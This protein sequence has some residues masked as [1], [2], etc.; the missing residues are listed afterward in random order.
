MAVGVCWL[1][2]PGDRVAVPGSLLAQWQDSP[3][4]P[5]FEQP[6][7]RLRASGCPFYQCAVGLDQTQEMPA[8]LQVS[9]LQQ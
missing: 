3:L 8:L 9:G 7:E 6:Q 2:S 5:P 4:Q 1:P